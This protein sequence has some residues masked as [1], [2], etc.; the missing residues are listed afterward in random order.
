MARRRRGPAPWERTRVSPQLPCSN[1]LGPSTITEED[2]TELT[3]LGWANPNRIEIPEPDETTPRT[4]EGY[5]PV[6]LRFFAGG[7]RFPCVPFIG[8]VLKHFEVE[9]QQITVN[10]LVRLA[11]FA[12]A[13]GGR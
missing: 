10:A 3:E 7:L 6:F 4:R 12:W 11:I 2:I 5:V 1:Y 13:V 8:E 9:L